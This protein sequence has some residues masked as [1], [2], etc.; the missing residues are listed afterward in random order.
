MPLF[1][2]K[3]KLLAILTP[4]PCPRNRLK[5]NAGYPKIMYKPKKI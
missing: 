5:L 4:E 3:L 1:I 2:S